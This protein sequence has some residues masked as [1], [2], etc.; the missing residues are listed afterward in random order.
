MDDIHLHGGRAAFFFTQSRTGFQP[1]SLY[2]VHGYHF[3]RKR[4]WLRWLAQIAERK[5]CRRVNLTVFVSQY[6]QK[7]AQRCRLL[8][9]SATHRVIYN[10]VS[11]DE[12]PMREHQRDRRRVAAVGR[13][14]F[15][16]DP[17]RV[18]DIAARLQNEG[19]CF[20]LIGGGEL[21]GEVRERV[22]K[23]GLHNV[24][25]HGAVSRQ[26]T[27]E[28]LSASGAFL[29]ASRWEGLPIAPLEAMICGV[30]VVLSDVGGNSE[31]VDHDVSGLL[32]AQTAT[33]GYVTA[34]R[35]LA[36]EPQHTTQLVAAA[37]I[38]VR[39]RFSREAM[40]SNYLKAYTDLRNNLIA[41][42]P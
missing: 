6:D 40:L 1:V 22:A 17:H 8:P 27:L 18:L 35:R 29:L 39:D 21:E 34:L 33:D 42:N 38:R 11:S 7:I 12:L 4:W 30:P 25:V 14:T 23:E 37:R 28:L 16:K 24:I 13:L 36:N 19:F 26:K 5:I 9:A 20:D 3:T 2:T 32:V 31:V 41:M 10:G 15:Q